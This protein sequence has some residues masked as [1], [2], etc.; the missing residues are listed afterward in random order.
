[1]IIVKVMGGLGNQFFQYA[2]YRQFQENGKE[3]YLDTSWYYREKGVDREYQLDLF[4]TKIQECSKRQKYM[5]AGDNESHAGIFYHK[6]FGGKRSHITESVTGEFDPAVLRMDNVYLD[7]Y[8]QRED[9]F[10]NIFKLLREELVL[11]EP[12][13]DDNRKILEMIEQTN[14][15]SIHVRRGDYI[16]FKDMYGGICTE[17]Y[18][19]D[20]MEYI[21]Q[22][23]RNAHFFVFSDDMDWCRGFFGEKEDITF[24]NINNENKNCCD[25]VLMSKCQNMII[26]NS[27]FS[28]WAAW[29]NGRDDKMIISPERWN[30]QTLASDIFCRGWIKLCGD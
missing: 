29:L 30:N 25:L 20:S 16:K 14:S 28:W 7:G 15:A 10:K 13:D 19:N 3:A 24:V 4:Q 8:W 6:I 12:L 17:K 1:M 22:H 23:V 2:L 18:Y 27:S 26:A 9:Y 11:K 5:L 21:K